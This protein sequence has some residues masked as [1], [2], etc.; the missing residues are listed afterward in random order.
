M[1]TILISDF[2]GGLQEGGLVGMQL[3]GIYRNNAEV[4]IM[5]PEKAIKHMDLIRYY[6]GG[7]CS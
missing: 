4:Y 6:R 1:I 3:D 2:W 5:W 7:L